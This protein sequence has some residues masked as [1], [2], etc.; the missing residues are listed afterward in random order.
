MAATKRLY[1]RARRDD[2]K[3]RRTTGP[4]LATAVRNLAE[5]KY[6]NV[7]ISHATTTA[8]S[9]TITD[10]A[11]GDGTSNRDGRKILTTSLSL[12]LTNT[13]G[14]PVR[15]ILYVPKNPAAFLTLTNWYDALEND[16]VW[17]LHDYMYGPVDNGD[18]NG[19][20]INFNMARRLTVEY[21]D[22]TGTSAV[23][24]PIKMLLATPSNS[25]IYGHCKLW[26]K[27]I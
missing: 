26:Y 5:S 16:E 4:S 15:V 23:R 9:T 3:R 6:K 20:L 17:V 25:T 2:A 27:D 22:T 12:K 10:V 18:A 19:V 24:N 13:S 7:S 21:S 8:S 11:A 14:F 1:Y